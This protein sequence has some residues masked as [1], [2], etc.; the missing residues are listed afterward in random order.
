LPASPKSCALQELAS[1]AKR[2]IGTPLDEGINGTRSI[3][4]NVPA[5]IANK[6]VNHYLIENITIIQQYAK[7][8]PSQDNF[9]R[10]RL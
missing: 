6:R 2:S 7:T 4:E 9:G 10:T 1:R 3:R 8:I 5:R